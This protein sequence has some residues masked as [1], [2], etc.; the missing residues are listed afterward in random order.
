MVIEV[1]EN[2]VLTKINILYF[3]ESIYGRQNVLGEGSFRVRLVCNRYG[4]E[5]GILLSMKAHV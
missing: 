3:S 2:E 5:G 4:I 1:V